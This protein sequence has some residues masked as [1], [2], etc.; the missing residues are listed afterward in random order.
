MLISLKGFAAGAIL[1][2]V[3]VGLLIY[4]KKRKR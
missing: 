4:F 1:F 2:V 3:D